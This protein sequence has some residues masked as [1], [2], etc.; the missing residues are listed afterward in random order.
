MNYKRI[1]I[2]IPEEDLKKIEEFC[3]AEKISKSFMIREAASKYISEVREQK[4]KEKKKKQIEW[5]LEAMEKL[6]KKNIKF[7]DGK[8]AEELI[9]ELRDSR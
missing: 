6:R 5:A 2:T 8:T 9:R 4:E 1:N 3:G 7:K